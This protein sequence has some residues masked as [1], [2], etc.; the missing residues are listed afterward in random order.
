MKME[1]SRDKMW[2]GIL[3]FVVFQFAWS[4]HKQY[5]TEKGFRDVESIGVKTIGEVYHRFISKRV[6]VYGNYILYN[7][8]VGNEVYNGERNFREDSAF[9]YMTYDTSLVGRKF[10]VKYLPNDPEINVILL[11]REVK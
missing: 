5:I 8:E 1:E 3:I 11:D 9:V 4:W 2:I 7:F 6:E 10:I